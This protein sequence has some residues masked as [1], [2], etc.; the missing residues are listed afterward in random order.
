M[1]T[2][3]TRK[4]GNS[5]KPTG[6][7][8]IRD[9]PRDAVWTGSFEF[10]Q[11]KLGRLP[12]KAEWTELRKKARNVR[13]WVQQ[14]SSQTK[15]VYVPV[16]KLHADKDFAGVWIGASPK[17]FERAN[18][19]FP[20]WGDNAADTLWNEWAKTPQ[21]LYWRIFVC[22]DDFQSNEGLFLTHMMPV[23]F[24]DPIV[25]HPVMCQSPKKPEMTPIPN[26]KENR[27]KYRCLG[28]LYYKILSR[29]YPV[30]SKT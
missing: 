21:R 11:G 13:E 4:P 5:Y 29:N 23:Y 28:T 30:S 10:A 1:L 26:E 8:A 18:G 3:Q 15:G 24:P 12:T 6:L 25:T 17:Y 19:G 20:N 16:G 9:W 14:A 2:S 27:W 22:T 7:Y